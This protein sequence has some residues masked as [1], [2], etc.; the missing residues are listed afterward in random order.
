MGYSGS[1]KTTFINILSLI[2]VPDM[3]YSK[4]E[5]PKIVFNL[6]KNDI[7]TITYLNEKIVAKDNNGNIV[8][9]ASV[10]AK[11]FGYIFQKPHMH[12]NFTVKQNIQTTSYNR[13]CAMR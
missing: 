10:R 4:G 11:I 12:D 6:S 1:G 8:D 3:E 5:N 2:D 13:K 7:Y 9:G